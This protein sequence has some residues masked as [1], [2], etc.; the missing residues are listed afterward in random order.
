[1][2]KLLHILGHIWCA[3]LTLVGLL[4][5]Y[6]GGGRFLTRDPDGV[7]YFLGDR[8]LLKAFFSMGYAGFCIG[9]VIVFNKAKHLANARLVKLEKRHFSQ[10]Q[11]LGLLMP[12]AYVLASLWALVR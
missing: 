2:K 6:L 3:P 8:F 11:V 10:F 4:V 9:G 12:L 7:F 5:A 1:M